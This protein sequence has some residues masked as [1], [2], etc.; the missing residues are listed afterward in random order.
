[1][2]VPFRLYAVV[3]CLLHAGYACAQGYHHYTTSEGLSGTDVTAICE[4]ESYLWVATNDGLNRFDGKR[5]TVYKKDNTS[6]NSLSENNI[7]SLLVDSRGLLWV[8]FKTGG[9]DIYDPRTD[10]FHHI[11]EFIPHYPQ[12]VVSIY[13]DSQGH[14]WLGSWGEGVFQLVP[15]DGGY[16]AQQ[17]YPG[18]VVSSIIEKPKGRLWFGTYYGIAGYDM[19]TG[20]WQQQAKTDYAITQFLD[21]GEERALW[22]SAWNRGV[23]RLQWDDAFGLTEERHS[24][25]GTGDSYRIHALGD[26][27]LLLGTWGN[28]I[29]VAT[30]GLDHAKPQPMPGFGQAMPPVVLSFFHDR[31][32]NLW[33]GTYGT[34][35]Y[36][37]PL[38]DRGFTASPAI[39]TGGHSAVSMLHP[40]AAGQLLVGTQGSGLYRYDFAERD[41]RPQKL[42]GG[43]TIFDQYILAGYADDRL[44]IV[45]NDDNGIHY[46]E[47]DRQAPDFSLRPFYADKNLTKVTAIFKDGERRFWIGTK[48]NGVIS[49]RYDTLRKTFTDYRHHD[50]FGQ[51]EITGFAAQSADSLWVSSHSGVYLFNTKNHTVLK[52]G[53][54]AAKEM[55]YGMVHDRVNGCLWLGTS[56]GLRRLDYRRDPNGI[57]AVFA[58]G[59]LPVG[60][61]KN[62]VLDDNNDLWF[63]LADRMFCFRSGRGQLVELNLDHWGGA[64]LTS[65]ARV[66]LGGGHTLVFGGKDRLIF[67][68]PQVALQQ[69]R[70][71]RIILTELEIDHRKVN[72]GDTVHGNVV[73]AEETEYTEAVSLSYLCKWI[74][75]SFTETGWSP[76]KDRYQYR[77]V[78]FSE[79]WQPLEL[80]KP[81]TFSQLPPGDFTLEIRRS[82]RVGEDPSTA[83][84]RLQLSIV[85]PWWKTAWFRAALAVLLI[86]AGGYLVRRIKGRYRRRQVLRLRDIEK[87]K[88]EELLQEKENFFMGLSHDLLTPFSLIIAPTKDL[89]QEDNL[90]EDQYEKLGIISKNASFLSD[91]F[92]AILDFKRI[93][94][95]GQ[96][97]QAV[98]SV[99]EVVSLVSMIV[100]VFEYAARSK[101]ITLAFSTDVNA[102]TIVTDTVK[103]ERIAYNLIS[104]ALK[105]TAEDGR[106]DVALGEVDDGY[107]TLSVQDNGAGIPPQHLGKIFNKFYQ[108]PNRP[109]AGGLGLGLYIVQQFA[110]A[111]GGTVH[112]ESAVGKGTR[113]AVRLPAR[114]ED[115]PADERN[116]EEP[117]YSVLIVED[118]DQLRDYLEKRLAAHFD[119][120]VAANGQE[121]LSFIQANY[122]EIVVADVMMPEVD[123]LELC[124]TIKQTPMY[125]DIFVVLLSARSSPEDELLGY[126]AGAD[127]YI[128]KPFDPEALVHQVRNL[129]STRHQQRKQA[130]DRLLETEHG[131]APDSK[132]QFL[133]RALQVVQGRLGDERFKINDLAQGMN[134]SKTVLHRKFKVIIGDT[135]NAFI[136]NV[137]IRSAAKMLKNSPLSVS[138][139]AYTTGFSQSHYFIK[140][141][142]EVFGVTP[143]QFRDNP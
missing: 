47:I 17:H 5:F 140:C 84:Y 23:Y 143:K 128:K 22:F 85:P 21:T 131:D 65:S 19:A 67:V 37:V 113:F 71:S 70:K 72:V 25:N 54:P 141:F 76:Y 122:P 57:E 32:D 77:V 11:G 123:G 112:V 114:P 24:D 27:R 73:L 61:V 96:E 49:L 115:Q 28:G 97:D 86:A 133:Q 90:T 136:R 120:A 36:R 60:T 107:F 92:G 106:V 111:M 62:L 75:L 45:G 100:Q 2:V 132:D 93:E 66:G 18:Y 34:G 59:N 102:L 134:L 121:A 20:R 116:G 9:A 105:Y 87:R 52:Q 44:L 138:E 26:G 14:I 63:T 99:V 56:V 81:L 42:L 64:P 88:R 127:C 31:Y 48:Q 40:W 104:N 53:D 68:D 29:K 51:D 13:E 69:S 110:T 83:D 126:K 39:G 98:A 12:R 125:A 38:G 129:Q 103:L 119:V 95:S 80:A 1:M 137:R 58:Q 3:I 41:F 130:L 10:R 109:S 101:R 4:N 135:P 74:S 78:G 117:A 142:K 139:I 89:L 124:K 35:L 55:T 16:T 118:N 6:A 30:P 15:T 50:G 7:E 94:L 79:R 82:D 8:G 33:I 46:A 43:A 108:Q 91:I